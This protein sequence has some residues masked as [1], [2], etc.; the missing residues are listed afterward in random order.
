[1][2]KNLH[3]LSLQQNLLENLP[4]ELGQLENLTELVST[5]ILCSEFQY[6]K[7]VNCVVLWLC[8]V[9]IFFHCLNK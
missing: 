7:A 2:L 3:S 5:D 4:E 9:V 8:P 6:L 1:M